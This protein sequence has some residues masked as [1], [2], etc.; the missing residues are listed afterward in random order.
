[1]EKK[2]QVSSFS[3]GNAFLSF[4]SQIRDSLYPMNDVESSHVAAHH[5]QRR[6]RHQKTRALKVG[7]WNY[8]RFIIL[9][10]G[11]RVEDVEDEQ[12]RQ[13]QQLTALDSKT[14]AHETKHYDTMDQHLRK[15]HSPHVPSSLSQRP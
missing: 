7:Q 14:L 6:P 10:N 13:H 2:R 5:R 3:H 15:T 1:M 9:E 8:I 11:T 12:K 4:V